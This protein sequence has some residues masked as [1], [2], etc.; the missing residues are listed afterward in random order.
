M[1]L[2]SFF[3]IDSIMV[4]N[5]TIHHALSLGALVGVDDI[6]NR[7]GVACGEGGAVTQGVI[8]QVLSSTHTGVARAQ[9]VR[10][11]VVVEVDVVTAL[12]DV[13]VALRQNAEELFWGLKEL[14]P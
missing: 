8:S 13:H 2:S 11:A 4:R 1:V 5:E 3:S 10:D 6:L 12:H 9:A 7:H 14:G